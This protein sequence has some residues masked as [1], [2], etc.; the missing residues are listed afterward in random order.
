MITHQEDNINKEID[1][2]KE[3]NRNSGIKKTL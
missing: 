2:N 3:P 1:V